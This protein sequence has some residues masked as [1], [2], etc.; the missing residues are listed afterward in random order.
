MFKNK[1]LSPKPVIVATT[2]F[3][4]VNVQLD[5]F[6]NKGLAPKPITVAATVFNTV[7]VLNWMCLTLKDKSKVRGDF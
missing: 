3:N 1:R 4:N 2:V 5:V 7:T 6:W